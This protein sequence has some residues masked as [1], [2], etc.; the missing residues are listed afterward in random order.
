MQ[1]CQVSRIHSQLYINLRIAKFFAMTHTFSKIE[2]DYQ[3]DF[4]LHCISCPFLLCKPICIAHLPR[5]CLI[6][7]HLLFSQINLL[8]VFVVYLRCRDFLMSMM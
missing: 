4:I 1:T 3:S 7:T 8:K 2:K 6:Y 5:P